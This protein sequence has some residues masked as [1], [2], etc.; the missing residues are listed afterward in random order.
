MV[1]VCCDE[2]TSARLAM[3]SCAGAFDDIDAAGVGLT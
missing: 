1:S 3:G 2:F